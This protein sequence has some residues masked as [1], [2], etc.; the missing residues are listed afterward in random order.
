[1]KDLTTYRTPSAAEAVAADLRVRGIYTATYGD[2]QR[3]YTIQVNEK[4]FESANE[5]LKSLN[6]SPEAA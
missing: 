2:K 4:D 3:G 6:H 1:M 5:M